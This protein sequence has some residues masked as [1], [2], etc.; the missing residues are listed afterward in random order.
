MKIYII[1]ETF[2]GIS[3]KPFLYVDKEQSI[4]ILR[5]M[6]TKN[7]DYFKNNL[8]LSKELILDKIKELCCES[9]DYVLNYWEISI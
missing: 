5:Q 4:D 8:I 1:Q 6:A 7:L 2:S 9:E 3:E